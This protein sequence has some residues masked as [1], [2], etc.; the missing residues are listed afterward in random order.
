MAA[1]A[2]AATAL[3]ACDPSA[4]GGLSTVAVALTTDQTGTRAL[5]QAGVDVQW[6]SCTSHVGE[7]PRRAAPGA[8][9]A[10]MRGG[11]PPPAPSWT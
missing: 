1:T 2:G 3:V 6:L 11:D 4:S 10:L 5:E 8:A 9:V 7:R